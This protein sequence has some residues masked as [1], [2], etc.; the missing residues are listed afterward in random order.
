MLQNKVGERKYCNRFGRYSLVLLL[1]LA[2]T[3]LSAQTFSDYKLSQSES[4]KKYKD[5]KDEAFNKYLKA[6]WEAYN[7]QI[8]DSFYEK[9]KPK[10][11]PFAEEKKGLV[12]GPKVKI[13][14]LPQ[15]KAIAIKEIHKDAKGTSFDFFGTTIG[16]EIP[17]GMDKANFSPPSKEGISNFFDEVVATDYSTLLNEINSVSKRMNLNG[18]GIYQLVIKLGD[19]IYSNEN[20]ARLLSWF[21]FNKM[22][23]GVKVGLS[24]ENVV[25]MHYSQKSIYSTPSYTIDGK[26][27]YVISNYSKN[28]VGSIY[29][30]KQNYPE[31][32]KPLNLTLESLPNLSENM[33]SKTLSFKQYGK[34]YSVPYDYN[35]N[36]IDFMGSYPQADYETFFNAPVERRSYE[37]IATA[38]KKYIDNKQS[39]E[40]I[41]FVLHFVQNAFIYK[42]DS[43]QF[44]REKVMFA[45]ETLYFDQSDCEDRAILFSYLVKELFNIG[46]IGVKYKDHMATALYLP[47]SGDS[48]NAGLKKYVI[49]DPTYVNASIGESMP[50]YKSIKPERFIVVRET[51]KRI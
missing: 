33:K 2:F 31:S 4:F 3:P 27:Y 40:A 19:S 45:E 11:L 39:S 44:G 16:F 22:G 35:Q 30:Y 10:V 26:R 20:E 50:K 28:Q 37:T 34:E 46:V 14:L 23:Y 21:L 48:I 51:T 32:E 29:T 9:P 13:E 38:L 49:A 7:A 24:Y 17:R 1:G 18:W 43:E 25:L 8:P 6:E 41:N 36:L 5:E 15:K 42:S 12:E 47:I